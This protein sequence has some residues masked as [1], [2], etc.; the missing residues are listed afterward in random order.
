MG[1][2]P[3]DR[4]D[5]VIAAATEMFASQGFHDVKLDRVAER[6]GVAKGTIYLYFK[7]KE[8]LFCECLTHGNPKLL[9]RAEAIVN[10]GGSVIERLH[11]LA[12]VQAAAFAQKGPL[13]QQM[14]HLGPAV[15]LNA[16]VLAR[17][18]LQKKRVVGVIAGLFQQGLDGGVFAA[19]FTAEQMA[20]IFMQ[21]FALNLQFQWFELPALTPDALCTALLKMFR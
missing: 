18:Q 1:R 10:R 15:A 14:F 5:R 2:P 4:R 19:H 9:E 8:D 11:E 20:L 17:I 7:S 16:E 21:F 6:A 12:G 3:S 13:I